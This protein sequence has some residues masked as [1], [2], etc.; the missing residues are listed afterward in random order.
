MKSEASVS[1]SRLLLLVT[2]EHVVPERP[3]LLDVAS[4]TVNWDAG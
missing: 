4:L 1:L 3:D 2:L